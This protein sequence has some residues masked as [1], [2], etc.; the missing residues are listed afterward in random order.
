MTIPANAAYITGPEASHNFLPHTVMHP[1]LDVVLQGYCRL[2][3]LSELSLPDSVGLEELQQF[4]VAQ[5][6]LD[7][8]LQS[9]PPSQQYQKT[10]WKW[11]IIELEKKCLTE[12]SLV[13]IWCSALT[14]GAG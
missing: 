8:H 11:Y 7:S 3:K 5:L 4:L 10:F 6:L 2:A 1:E 13:K 12:V 14:A 9:Y